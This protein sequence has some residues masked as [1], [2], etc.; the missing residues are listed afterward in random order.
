MIT[1][2]A[3]TL[4]ESEKT[5]PS[6]RLLGTLGM[7]GAPMMLLEGLYRSATHLRNNHN[8]Y[9]VGAMS[10]LYI[11][12]WASSSLGMRRLR[13]TGDSAASRAAFAVQMAGLLLAGVWALREV[14]KPSSDINSTLF[15]V[16]D[17]AWPLSHIFM[18]VI[19]GLVLKADVWRGWR[20]LAPFLC[21]LALPTFFAASTVVRRESAGALF[22]IF[23]ALG[24]MLQGYAVRKNR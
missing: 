9:V 5:F 18:L 17:A 20:R 2:E 12:G 23:T 16:T 7:I 13:V 19:G 24:F 15:K 4:D 10:L 3:R 22:G 21:G 11:I 1:E 14:V 6:T 8:D